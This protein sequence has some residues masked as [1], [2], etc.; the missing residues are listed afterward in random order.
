MGGPRIK[1]FVAREY[2]YASPNASDSETDD[3]LVQRLE[4][5]FK[6]LPVRHLAVKM[7]QPFRKR[8]FVMLITRLWQEHQQKPVALAG[9]HKTDMVNKDVP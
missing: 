2:A 7:P 3:E 6:P 5:E 1:S 9:G 4:A 8:D